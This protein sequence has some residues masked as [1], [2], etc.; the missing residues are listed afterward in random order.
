MRGLDSGVA[1][2]LIAQ[3]RIVIAG[4]MQVMYADFSGDA[5]IFQGEQIGE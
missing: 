4:K 5:F 1:F 2:D 3:L